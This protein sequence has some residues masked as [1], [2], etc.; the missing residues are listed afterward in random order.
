MNRK[1]RDCDFIALVGSL[2]CRGCNAGKPKVH[3]CSVCGTEFEWSKKSSWYGSMRD[4]DE[5]PDNIKK[6][7]NEQCKPHLKDLYDRQN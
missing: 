3:K 1:C 5:F 4:E 6:A 2:L 7:C